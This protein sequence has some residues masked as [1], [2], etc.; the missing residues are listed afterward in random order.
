MRKL[1]KRRYRG[2]QVIILP[3]KQNLA[4]HLLCVKAG[5]FYLFY[6]THLH[7]VELIYEQSS[8]ILILN[9]GFFLI[10]PTENNDHHMVSRRKKYSIPSLLTDRNEYS[11]L[12]YNEYHVCN[13]CVQNM[14]IFFLSFF[15]KPYGE[16]LKRQ[17]Q[18]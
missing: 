11:L 13:Q 7:S 16:Q 2:R 10:V 14:K 3:C 15:V 9:D 8:E 4:L 17:A 5:C 1:G 12:H 18:N 6:L